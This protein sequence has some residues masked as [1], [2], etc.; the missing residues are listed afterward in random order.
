MT[1]KTTAPPRRRTTL[2]VPGLALAAVV[3]AGIFF[4]NRDRAAEPAV[5]RA[6]SAAHQVEV[7]LAE[8]RTG[9]LDL[10][11]TVA[12]T[13]GDTAGITGVSVEAA[14]PSMGHATSE[15]PGTAVGSGR[16]RFH[17]ELFPMTGQWDLTVHVASVG[18]PDQITLPVTVTR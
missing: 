6:G 8:P 1:S 16:Y 10:E 17:G 9:Q 4:V 15:L 13:G 12:A 5:L 7:H 18:G 14:M 3:A 11:L 2:L